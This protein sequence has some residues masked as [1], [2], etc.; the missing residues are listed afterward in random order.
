MLRKE[1]QLE[2]EIESLKKIQKQIEQGS[3]PG[4]P[5]KYLWEHE[6]GWLDLMFEIELIKEES[7]DS[8]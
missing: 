8:D 5:K 2:K 7:T 4:K 1:N 3:W 6:L